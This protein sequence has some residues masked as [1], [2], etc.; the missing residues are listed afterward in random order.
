MIWYLVKRHMAPLNF[1]F[2]LAHSFSFVFYPP[3][4][5]RHCLFSASSLPFPSKIPRYSLPFDSFADRRE[6]NFLIRTDLLQSRKSR[7]K[8]DLTS[9][10]VCVEMEYDES[11]FC[12]NQSHSFIGRLFVYTKSWKHFWTITKFLRDNVRQMKILL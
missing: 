11:N 1:S 9:C 10:H 3:P 6:I 12:W 5:R 2:P 8:I 7:S 4:L